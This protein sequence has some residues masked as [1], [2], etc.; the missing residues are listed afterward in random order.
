MTIDHITQRGLRTGLALA[1]TTTTALLLLSQRE[2][3]S[4]WAALN[5]VAHI[6]DG[7]EKEQPTAFSPRESSLGLVVNATAMVVWG[8][9][10]E[11]SLAVIHRPAGLLPGALAALAAYVIDY[12]IVPKRLAP[13]IETRLSP[14]SV[15]AAYAVLAAT[16]A[17]SS[18]WNGPSNAPS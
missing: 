6:I 11:G 18:T 4:P 16:L 17:A 2:H 13:G 5:A 14:P 12:K 9:L 10:Y 15:L 3:G 7:D 1:T 8:V